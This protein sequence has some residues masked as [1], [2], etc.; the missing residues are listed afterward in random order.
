MNDNNDEKFIS[1]LFAELPRKMFASTASNREQIWQRVQNHI[2]AAKQQTRRE[3]SLTPWQY[4]ILPRTLLRIGAT[5]IV[6][7]LALTLVGG[8][9]YATPGQTLYPVKIAAEQV[10]LVLATNDEAKV[11]V[12]IKHAKRRLAEVQTLVQE[13]KDSK[14]VAQT[15]D[16]LK[17]TTDELVQVAVTAEAQ[18]ELANRAS[19]LAAEQE[20]ILS[21]VSNTAPDGELKDAVQNAITAAKDSITKLSSEDVKGVS[22]TTADPVITPSTTSKTIASPASASVKPSKKDATLDGFIQIDEV[23]TIGDDRQTTPVG[24]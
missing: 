20:Q 13:N 12:G 16:A 19:E 5:V 10:E 24:K 7:V 21:T 1:Q 2:R 6:V 18:P 8:V 15:L 9:A 4:L 3:R 22:A 11:N 23:I 17:S 14:I